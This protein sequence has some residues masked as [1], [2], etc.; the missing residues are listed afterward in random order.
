V[1][2]PAMMATR[3]VGSAARTQIKLAGALS[4]LLLL[5]PPAEAQ[6]AADLAMWRSIAHSTNPDE[7]RAYLDTFP[8]GR[9]AGLARLRAATVPPQTAPQA[10]P[11]SVPPSAPAQTGAALPPATGAWLRPV[12]ARVRLVDGVALDLDARQ[13]WKSSNLRVIVVP[14]GTPETITDMSEYLDSSTSVGAKRLHLTVP[15]GPPGTDEVR[16]YH[17][18]PFADAPELAAR[19]VVFIA[20]GAPGATLARTLA[21]EAARLGPV[22]FEANHRNRPLLVQAAYLNQQPRLAFDP[23]WLSAFG[24]DL[25]AETAVAVT[26]G[27]PGIAPDDMGVVGDVVCT[28][29][30]DPGPTLDRLAALKV[31]DPILVRGIPTIWTSATAADPVILKDCAL[32]Q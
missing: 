15:S 8:N 30:A 32:A 20:A 11:P 24:A 16:L 4:V 18:A 10:S 7:Y 12:H 31:G 19:A 3:P 14:A 9:F 5:S 21:R 26:I 25:P 17:I 1:R 28:T 2:D 6:D 13:L 22:R 27:M 29:S 23:R